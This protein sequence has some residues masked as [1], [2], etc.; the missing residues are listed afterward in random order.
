MQN[1]TSGPYV[2]PVFSP[3]P[4]AVAVNALF[5]ASLGVVLIA[6]FLCMLA[7][8]W[9]RE[10]D[11]KLQ[12][13]PD[14]QKRAAIK[15][16]RAQG[17]VRWRLPQMIALLPSLIHLSLV[18]FF[19]GLALYLLQVHKLPAFLL[20]SIFGLGVLLYGFSIF[21]SASDSFSPFGSVYS[22]ALGA[23]YH[24]QYSRLLSPLIYGR[25][26]LMALPQ[27]PSEKIRE[28]I[29]TF[30]RVHKPFLDAGTL[31][32]VISQ[33]SVPVLNN[34]W[35]FVSRGWTSAY[36]KDIFTSILLQLDDLDIRS[37]RN[38]YILWQYET[39]N[40]SIKEAEC[41]VYSTCMQEYIPHSPLFLG[42]ISASLELLE[43]RSD[44]WFH[45]MALLIQ[46]KIGDDTLKLLTSRPSDELSLIKWRPP[47]QC[48]TAPWEEELLLA[49]SG[50]KNYTEAQWSFLLSAI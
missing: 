42:T 40:R 39:K 25:S 19:I 8:G 21:I 43:Q 10:L 12:G 28:R 38:W 27:T 16:L 44:P 1:S 26:S 50:V 34:L 20:I 36:T 14:L 33:T 11:R 35:T 41:L 18:L 31:K 46:M 13:I 4:Y 29:S 24:R 7:K 3:P 49:I 15:E 17:L 47:I 45:L 22:R 30:L 32:E 6:A 2:A 48:I 5:F 9:I 23:L 37:P